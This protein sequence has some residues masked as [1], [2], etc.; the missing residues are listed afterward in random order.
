MTLSFLE[1][2][3]WVHMSTDESV[4]RE[5]A[6]QGVSVTSGL[7]L[8]YIHLLYVVVSVEAERDSEVDPLLG[9]KSVV[10]LRG[11][12]QLVALWLQRTMST[13]IYEPIVHSL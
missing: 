3:Q 8:Y 7:R 5:P 10:V 12:N 2:R 1:G 13:T 9:H 6:S 4:H 11:D